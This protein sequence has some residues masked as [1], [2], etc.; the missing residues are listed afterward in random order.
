MA[1]RAGRRGIDPEGKCV[2]A[3]DVRDGLEEMRRVGDGDSEPVQSQFKLG[4]GSVALLLRSGSDQATGR[5]I[6]ESSFGQYQNL[7]RVR[8]LE[9]EAGSLEAALGEARSEEHTS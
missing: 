4:Y 6:V 1:G 3:L 7:K 2:M 5:R 8:A 9:A